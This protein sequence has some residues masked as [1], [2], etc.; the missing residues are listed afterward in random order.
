[1]CR[2][3]S[4]DAAKTVSSDNKTEEQAMTNLSLSLKVFLQTQRV[5]LF[6]GPREQRVRAVLD[7]G[8]HRSYI[9]GHAADQLRFEQ[10]V[11]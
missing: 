7:T 9:S 1:M 3:V 8:S 5:K 4:S 6:N 10:W 11:K 2:N